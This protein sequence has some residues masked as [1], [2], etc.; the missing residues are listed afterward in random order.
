MKRLA[1]ALLLLAMA[2]AWAGDRPPS[3]TAPPRPAAITA[4]RPLPS[5]PP[6]VP[7]PADDAFA[8]IGPAV[9][10]AIAAHELPGC[11]VEIG[12]RDEILFRRAYGSRSVEPARTPMTANTLFDLASLTKPIATATSI[13]ILVERGEVSLDAP[14][15][16]YV[17]ELAPLPPFTVRQLLL[18]ESGLAPDT[19][20]SDYEHGA[21]EAMRRVARRRPRARPGERFVYSD[22]GYMVLGEIVRRVSGEDL[23]AFAHDAIFAP[24]GMKETMFTPPA[25]LKKRA[26]PTEQRG[27]AWIVGDV[28]DPRAFAL[29]GVAG[30]AGLFSTADDLARFARAMLGRGELDGHRIFS[31]ATAR[32]FFARRA[33]G[34]TLGWDAA[35]PYATNKPKHGDWSFSDRAFGHGGYTGTALWIDPE[36]DLFVVFLSN[37]VHPDG[38]G[39]VN[40]LIADVGGLAVRAAQVEPGIDVLC[41]EKFARLRGARVALLTNASARARD[42]TTTIDALRRADG[43]EL[44]SLLSPEHGLGADRDAKVGDSRFDGLPVYSLYGARFDPPPA[45]LAGASTIVFD[46]QDAGVRFYTYASTMRRAMRVAARRHLR[47]V[48]LDRPDP[49]DGVD[50]QGPVFSGPA[51]FVNAA[52]LPVRHGMTMGELARMFAAEDGTGAG[53][54]VV[55]MR[56]WRRRQYYDAT[57]LPWVRP[58]PSLRTVDEAVLYPAIGLLEGTNLSVGRGTDAPF[59]Q[60][61]AP[62]IDGDA[63]VRD[64]RGQAPRGRALRRDE[65]LTGVVAVSRRG[66][67]RRP[68]R[69]D[70]PRALPPGA[71]RAGHRA[72]PPR[73]LPVAMASRRDGLPARER[74]HTRRRPPRREPRGRDA[75]MGRR[76][77][78]FQGE[79]GAVLALP[80]RPAAHDRSRERERLRVGRSPR[81]GALRLHD[82]AP[83]SGFVDT[84]TVRVQNRSPT[85]S[86]LL[87][88]SA[89]ARSGSSA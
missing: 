66:V 20:V 52:A 32:R 28:S 31:K 19:P 14:A 6:P 41:D 74:A 46:L 39:H 21:A 85:I 63:L 27:G 83:A 68:R 18:H 47:F 89:F 84:A 50:V 15:S 10:A 7:L 2:A 82:G 48:V 40:P 53:L 81:A 72:R 8:A 78:R 1:G 29:G 34:R 44:V 43:L 9:Q 75:A 57:G 61:G 88:H 80:V 69:R 55:P 33:N 16:Q 49:L 5:P 37:R 62:W 17:P 26:A 67:P 45:A 65:L 42:G 3:P 24:L 70:R 11:V 77:R 58:S 25:T 59:E 13:M 12:T 36:R 30:H 73:Q 87:A 56:G 54:E 60:L 51:S 76:T 71:R 64:L 86:S 35:S 22:V 23:A 38:K 4:P 79:A